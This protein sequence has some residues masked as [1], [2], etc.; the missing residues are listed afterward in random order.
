MSVFAPDPPGPPSNWRTIK[1]MSDPI[2]FIF[3][4]AS[5]AS[6]SS[7]KELSPESIRACNKSLTWLLY[8]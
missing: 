1:S 7:A 3:N 8:A 6:F 5:F 2:F 4:K